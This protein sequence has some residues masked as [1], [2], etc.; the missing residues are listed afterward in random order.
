MIMSS[1]SRVESSTRRLADR[2]LQRTFPDLTN[3]E[4]ATL[5]ET[6]VRGVYPA[7]AEII[8]QGEKGSTLYLLA[9][10]AADVIVHAEDG[11]ELLVD[12]ISPDSYF[13]EMSFFGEETR[14]ATI[15]AKQH[16]ETVEIDQADFMTVAQSNPTL[17]QTLLKQIIGHMR[18]NDRA[19]IRE[20][21]MKTAIVQDAYADLAEQEQLRSQFIAT[22]SHEL[23]TP[24]TSI[25]GFLGLI[26]QGAITGDSLRVAMQSITRNVEQMV[27]L[28]NNLLILYEMYPGTPEY[29]Y[30]NPA[31]LVVTALNKTQAE[32]EDEPVTVRL[33]IADRLPEVH[34]DKQGVVLAIR[35]LLENA[36]KFNPDRAPIMVRVYCPDDEH[37]AAAVVDEGIGIPAHA[38]ERIFEPFY[39][40]ERSGTSHL[41]P[42]LG[43]GLTIAQFIVDRHNGRIIVESEPGRGS[44][45][46]IH[47]P[48]Q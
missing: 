6:A 35:A 33:D 13:G 43:V 27:G 8:R 23:R 25:K 3:D 31:D 4:R 9:S 1:Q 7:G 18:R 37:V 34:V 32:L 20:L 22:L 2:L 45:F 19:V 15:R 28:T 47:L 14:L 46:T 29:D 38:H 48:L 42:G 17:L 26:N 36:I 30:H 11:Q 44:T 5:S 21:N 16:C 40:L 41:F 10:G 24:L 39:R 12:T